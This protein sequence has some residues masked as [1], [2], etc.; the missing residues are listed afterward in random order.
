MPSKIDHLTAKR[1]LTL[2][3]GAMFLALGCLFTSGMFVVNTFV[4][5]V[6]AVLH[7]ILIPP[8]H[9]GSAWETKLL[10][11]ICWIVFPALYF[12]FVFHVLPFR[13]VIIILYTFIGLFV[14]WAIITDIRWLRSQQAHE[15]QSG[16]D[17]PVS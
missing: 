11:G 17:K 2:A 12:L 13:G 10:Q 4:V 3:W 7:E 14:V 5:F 6:A 1:R 16:R 15:E 9:S 8:R